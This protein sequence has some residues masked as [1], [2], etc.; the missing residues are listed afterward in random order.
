MS[1]RG[2]MLALAS[3]AAAGLALL[4]IAL[5]AGPAAGRGW[6]CAFVLVSM[7]PI[8]ALALLLVH[9]ISGGRWAMILRR[10]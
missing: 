3:G 7:V 4:V 6:L 8:G 2:S 9:G 10:S 5:I 1:H